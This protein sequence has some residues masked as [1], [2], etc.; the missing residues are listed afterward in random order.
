MN[1]RPRHF[2]KDKDAK[3]RVASALTTRVSSKFACS[4]AFLLFLV[5]TAESFIICPPAC[6]SSVF[7]RNGALCVDSRQTRSCSRSISSG[8]LARKEFVARQIFSPVMTTAYGGTPGSGTKNVQMLSY[9][10]A[11]AIWDGLKVEVGTFKEEEWETGR[12]LLNLIIFDGLSVRY[13]FLFALA[14]YNT[15]AD[16]C[17]RRSLHPWLQLSAKRASA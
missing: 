11:S 2:G 14:C 5:P 4:L 6:V 9:L 12:Q 7:S 8:T 16:V 17:V 1:L 15:M 3:E 10:P 13:P